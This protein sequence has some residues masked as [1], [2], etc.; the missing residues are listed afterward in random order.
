MSLK[1]FSKSVVTV[2]P[3]SGWQTPNAMQPPVARIQFPRC[4]GQPTI[5]R[6]RYVYAIPSQGY[7][8]RMLHG[9]EVYTLWPVEI[10]SS[11]SLQLALQWHSWE[12]N[13]AMWL[14]LLP[15]L[16]HDHIITLKGV[17]FLGRS[18]SFKRSLSFQFEKS[19]WTLYYFLV[20]G[21]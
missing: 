14:P 4:M 6:W 9:E 1:L 8:Q 15:V 7:I 2:E 21:A 11:V 18:F 16:L 3:S 10:H 5:Y 20:E 12:L 17:T 13:L 19:S